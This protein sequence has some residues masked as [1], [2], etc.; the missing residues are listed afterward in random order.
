MI[1]RYLMIIRVVDARNG[2]LCTER[3]MTYISL[4]IFVQPIKDPQITDIHVFV[5]QWKHVWLTLVKRILLVF[6][7]KSDCIEDL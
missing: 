4:L 7:L 3:A 1:Y 6:Y 5:G 2:P